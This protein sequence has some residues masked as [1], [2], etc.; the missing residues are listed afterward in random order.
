MR[1][2]SHLRQEVRTEEGRS[3]WDEPVELK[4]RAGGGLWRKYDWVA[5]QNE[6]ATAPGLYS[7][8]TRK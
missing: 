5:F 2:F 6:S 8:H 3:K 1:S 4:F 7:G